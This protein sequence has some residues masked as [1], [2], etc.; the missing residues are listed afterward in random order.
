MDKESMS[1]IKKEEEGMLLQE[2]MMKKME[3]YKKEIK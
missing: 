3:E 1:P 2:K